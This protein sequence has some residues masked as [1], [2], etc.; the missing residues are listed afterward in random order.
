MLSK[1]GDRGWAT[2]WLCDWEQLENNLHQFGRSLAKPKPYH[3][4]LDGIFVSNGVT[5]S[6]TNTMKRFDAG[7]NFGASF[8]IT[9][10]LSIQA[11]Y[12]LGLT[13]VDSRPDS[14]SGR[15]FN[16]KNSVFQASLGYTFNRYKAS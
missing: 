9:K 13:E 8:S 4:G 6:Y 10:K 7:V 1:T 12:N 11:R 16:N 14:A 15:K 2:V 5:Y 3:Q